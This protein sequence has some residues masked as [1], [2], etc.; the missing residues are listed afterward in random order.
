M[1]ENIEAGY[2]QQEGAEFAALRRNYRDF[3]LGEMPLDMQNPGVQG[4]IARLDREA[5]NYYKSLK[6]EGEGFFEDLC[7]QPEQTYLDQFAE[8]PFYG[9]T[10]ALGKTVCRLRDIAFAF[11]TPGCV[12]CGDP[13]V[14]KDL[15][16]AV[17]R[18][19]QQYFTGRYDQ[20]SGGNW[21]PWV[22]TI[23]TA[24]LNICMVLYDEMPG[25]QLEQC[26]EICRHYV[27]DCMAR[28]P[29]SND[30]EMTG[31]N[32]LLKANSTLQTGILCR[33]ESLLDNV[34]QG[35]RK[36]LVCNDAS[37]F[38]EGCAD[39]FFKDGS[40]IQHQ[41]LAYIG[42]Y[43]SDLYCNLALF[44]RVLKGSRWQIR[45][46]D[47]REKLALDTVFL[48]I[49]PFLYKT[50]MMDMVSGRL[51]TRPAQSDLIRQPDVLN[52]ILPL[53][54]T[55]LTEEE[56]R[57]FDRMMRYYLELRPEVFYSRMTSITAILQA[58]ELLEDKTLE[59]LGD[60]PM[61]RV[62]T[63]DKAVHKTENFAFSISMHSAR[64][65]AHELINSEG[66][67]TWNVGDGM[68]YLYNEDE[69]QYADG[70]WAAVDPARL[71]G[72]TAEQAEL[73]RGTGDRTKNVYEWVGGATLEKQGLGAVGCH[74]RTVNLADQ[75]EMR[76]PPRNRRAR[77]GADVKK[78][79]FLFG[80]RILALGSGIISNTGNRVETILENRKIALDAHN[81]VFLN[82]EE[83]VLPLDKAESGMPS[84]NRGMQV[85]ARTLT[86]EGEND[87][88][89]SW[90]FPGKEP[91]ELHLL[92]ER[93]IGQWEHQGDYTGEAEA[94]FFTALFDHGT[95][96]K[97]AGYA[98]L[99]LPGADQ[100]AAETFAANP[101]IEVLQND[102]KAAAA[103]DRENGVTAVNF[104]QPGEVAEIKCDTPASVLL[105]REEGKVTLAVADPCQR[106]RKIR[107]VLP[108]E[109]QQTEQE[110]PNVRLLQTGPQAEVEFDTRGQEGASMVVVFRT[111]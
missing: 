96:P 10:E 67:R 48:G 63:M 74:L 25:E 8:R 55:F 35:V 83:C 34:W 65:Y 9:Y 44:M 17:E 82:G 27:P 42:G 59:P 31:G 38:Y 45:Y 71:P 53:R 2:K 5:G 97:D 98:Y 75:M 107:I 104:W 19:T 110:T 14:Q 87:S 105:R 91:A 46:P 30:P 81:K 15:L 41:A 47:G 40:Y 61:T 33:D 79:W 93:R 90:Y 64:T 54:G 39:G 106:Q 56:N 62:F 6:K 60:Q 80:D 88:R 1:A 109:V 23:P 58:A 66:K 111:V 32:L 52:A 37:A 43:G 16:Q 24:L 49:E 50:H 3:L 85:K 28:G 102:E 77:S 89:I 20:K 11:K 94:S 100:E 18:V 7:I 76:N 57:R 95:N 92:K 51:I 103:V 78:S 21:Y 4:Y 36:V 70:F 72:I 68:T 12:L 26:A 69:R 101:T 29:H 99:I 84:P 73:G 86:L 13:L 22:V 108:F